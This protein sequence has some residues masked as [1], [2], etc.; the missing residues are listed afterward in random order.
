MVMIDDEP[1]VVSALVRLLSQDGAPVDIAAH[2]LLALAQIQTHRYDA[3]LCDLL[4]P[5][6]KGPDCSVSIPLAARCDIADRG[7][8]GGC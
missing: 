5:E 1:S 6:L 3:V 8:L 2:G 7:Y 4:M